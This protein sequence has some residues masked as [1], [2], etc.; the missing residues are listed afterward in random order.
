V[1]SFISGDKALKE[2]VKTQASGEN[3]SNT[4]QT[5]SS[6]IKEAVGALLGKAKAGSSASKHSVD[7]IGEKIEDKIIKKET[8]ISSDTRSG[9]LLSPN[10]SCVSPTKSEESEQSSVS[11]MTPINGSSPTSSTNGT[12]SRRQSSALN[13]QIGTRLEAKDL[14]NEMW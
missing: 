13:F 9:H 3:S 11:D 10:T 14:G 6:E 1:F 2:E 4:S 7:T 5:A 8:D 12:S